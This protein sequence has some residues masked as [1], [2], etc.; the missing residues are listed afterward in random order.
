[1]KIRVGF[2]LGVQSATNDAERFG[3]FVD[4]LER[5]RVRLAVAERAHQRRGP[6]PARRPGLRCGPHRP[7][8]SSGMSVMVLP[9]RNPVV[10]AKELATPRPAVER[11][12]AAGLRP[13]RRRSATSSRPS[14]SSGAS[15][16]RSSTRSLPLLRRLWTEDRVDHEGD[17]VPLRRRHRAAQAG[18]AADRR[19]DG[20]H[21]P[22]RDPAGRP[23]ERRL[24]A[25]VLHR[26]RHPRPASRSSREA[27][28]KH[29]RE[30]DPEHFGALVAYADGALPDLLVERLASAAGP[31]IDPAEIIPDG[32]RRGDGTIEQMVEVG[33]SKFVVLPLLEP[34]EAGP[35]SSRSVAAAL[36][37]LAELGTRAG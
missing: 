6:R 7:S 19:V 8:S 30:I 13:R 33:A 36:L 15:G 1:M 27:A 32:P 25:L 2:A 34:A 10:L 26:R 11:S 17:L 14:G 9:G 29:E 5:L 16:R 20:R 23:P 3:A 4:D 37:P 28:D 18:P 22:E 31:T 24:A 35:P 21:R 12:S